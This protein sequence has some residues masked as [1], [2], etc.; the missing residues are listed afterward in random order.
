[1]RSTPE[2]RVNSEPIDA[3]LNKVVCLLNAALD[4]NKLRRPSPLVNNNSTFPKL[5]QNNTNFS[6]NRRWFVIFSRQL[7]LHCCAVC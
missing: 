7:Y 1:M 4:E 5:R 6:E 2:Q 3:T